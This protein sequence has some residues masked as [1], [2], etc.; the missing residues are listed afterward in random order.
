MPRVSNLI[1][2]ITYNK[3][4]DEL[5]KIGATAKISVKLKAIIAAKK[6]GIT[7]VSEIFDITRKTLME[8]IK[9]FKSHGSEQLVV[10]SGRGRKPKLNENQLKEIKIWVGQNPN[11]TIKE[12]KIAIEQSFGLNVSMA[13]VNRILKKPS[14]SYITP[15]PRHNKQDPLKQEEFKKKFTNHN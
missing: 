7:K 9:S 4:C 10:Q 2:D 14:F 3:A 8:W 11:T 12:L 15:R 6:Y 5:R 1:D 13:T